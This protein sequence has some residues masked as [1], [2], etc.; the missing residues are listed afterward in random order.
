MTAPCALP[1]DGWP[2][3][4]LVTYRQYTVLR[5]ML[6]DGA[7]N[8]QIGNRLLLTEDTIKT[9]MRRIFTLLD[10]R[11]RLGACIAIWSGAVDVYMV[12]ADGGTRH[13]LDD[14]RQ[15]QHAMVR[16]EA[17]WPKTTSRLGT[18]SPPPSPSSIS[19]PV[20]T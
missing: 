1:E 8:R 15:L 14:L 2:N 6:F 11:D 17:E 3:P 9:H 10:V 7:S 18:G 13:L 4:V 19:M 5:A 16:K 12:N 20:A